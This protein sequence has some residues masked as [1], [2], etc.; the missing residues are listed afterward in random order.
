MQDVGEHTQH[1]EKNE[2]VDEEENVMMTEEQHRQLMRTMIAGRPY[3]AAPA[4]SI[5]SDPPTMTSNVNAVS[6]SALPL[7]ASHDHGHPSPSF[8]IHRPLNVE[9]LTHTLRI[10]TNMSQTVDGHP[11]ILEKLLMRA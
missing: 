7:I 3:T 6:H 1:D 9:E 4:P 11:L 5:P 2:H 8:S 10:H